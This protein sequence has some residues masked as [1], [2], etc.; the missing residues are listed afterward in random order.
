MT[1]RDDTIV[2]LQGI[3]KWV[4]VLTW[5]WGKIAQTLKLLIYVKFFINAIQINIYVENFQILGIKKKH[6]S[7][8]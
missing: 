8:N 1:T 5:L 6:K 7:L 3:S 2:G 4:D